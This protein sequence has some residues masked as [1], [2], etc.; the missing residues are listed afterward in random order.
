VDAE[1]ALIVIV[2]L[3]VLAAF[4]AG[5]LVALRYLRGQR[6]GDVPAAVRAADLHKW[7][8]PSLVGTSLTLQP[9]ESL[10]ATAN[11]TADADAPAR[12]VWVDGEDEALVHL[13]SLTVRTV[14]TTL[15][16]SIELE[17]DETGR[18]PVIV[19]F[20]MGGP[21]DPG[22]LHVATDEVPHGPPALVSRWG[23]SVQAALWGSVVGL[24]MQHADQRGARLAAIGVERGSLVFRTSA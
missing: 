7:I 14:G 5:V 6:P 15:V 23:Q 12:V 10:R 19:R 2:A 3:L 9:G 1:T 20:A 11:R 17:T 8:A 24:A 13:D 21:D 18:A 4:V 16:M 22:G